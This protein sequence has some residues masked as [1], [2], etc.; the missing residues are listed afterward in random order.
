MNQHHL[1]DVGAIVSIR[2]VE[3]ATPARGAVPRPCDWCA[4][5]VWIAPTGLR[6][7]RRKS[8]RVMCLDCA[9]RLGSDPNEAVMTDQTL[10]E[11]VEATGYLPTQ[12]E[13]KAAFRQLLTD[14]RGRGKQ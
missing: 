2:C 6:L 9:A 8:L 1:E 3:L 4:W 11:I 14:K 13:L 12:H 7:M 10:A 5:S